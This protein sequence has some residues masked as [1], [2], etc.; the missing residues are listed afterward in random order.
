MPTSE[1]ARRPFWIHQLAEYVVGLL[2]VSS[3]LQ[4]PDPVVPCVVG[5][6]VL[7]NAAVTPGPLGAFTLVPRRVHAVLDVVLVGVILV[8]AVQPWWSIDNATRLIMVGVAVVLGLVTF[9]T[10]FAERRQR[11]ER[12]AAAAATG[13]RVGRSAGRLAGSAVTAWRQRKQ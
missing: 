1:R 3:G 9:Y 7:V 4:A 11:A 5:G 2:L 12:R 10:D 8:A 6:L 13:E